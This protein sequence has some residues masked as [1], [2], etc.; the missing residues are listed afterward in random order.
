MH[1]QHRLLEK[2]IITN[3]V[4]NSKIYAQLTRFFFLLRS[5]FITNIILNSEVYISN[6]KVCQVYLIVQIQ[7]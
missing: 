4:L 1:Q 5:L 7:F 3:T 6:N 2:S